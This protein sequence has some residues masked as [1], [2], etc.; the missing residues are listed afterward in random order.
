MTNTVI[1]ARLR[2]SIE[3]NLDKRLRDFEAVATCT[4][5]TLI[6]ELPYNTGI[7]SQDWEVIRDTVTAV[8]KSKD[9]K[10][11]SN[12]IS[13]RDGYLAVYFNITT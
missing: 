8:L 13:P 2:A 3:R 1:G 11:S 6:I 5:T 9:L 10:Y 7:A 12:C 4:G